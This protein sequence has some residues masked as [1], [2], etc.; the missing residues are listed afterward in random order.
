MNITIISLLPNTSTNPT[1]ITAAIGASAAI[2]GAVV[3]SIT[4]YFIE[5]Q[6][7]KNETKKLLRDERKRIYTDLFLEIDAFKK[8]HLDRF[9][10]PDNDASDLYGNWLWEA[11]QALIN[12]NERFLTELQ[13]NGNLEIGKILRESYRYLNDFTAS[14]SAYRSENAGDEGAPQK[15]TDQNIK[16]IKDELGRI[17]RMMRAELIPLTETRRDESKREFWWE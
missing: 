3:S 16:F 6:K 2:I 5:K 10:S 14:W 13:L 15:I 9:S 1:L 17:I 8:N 11:D 7:F 4:Y 12:L